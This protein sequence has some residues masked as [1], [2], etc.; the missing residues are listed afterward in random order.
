MDNV[1]ATFAMSVNDPTPPILGNG[2][3]ITPTVRQR[4]KTI[5]VAERD[6]RNL[7]EVLPAPNKTLVLIGPLW[8][9]RPTT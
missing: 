9:I 8:V 3:A 2:A 4:S 6:R 5:V 1:A 7:T